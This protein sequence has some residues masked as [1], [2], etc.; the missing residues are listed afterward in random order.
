MPETTEAL[1]LDQKVTETDRQL[2]IHEKLHGAAPTI[3]FT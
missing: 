1:C 2:G 3:V